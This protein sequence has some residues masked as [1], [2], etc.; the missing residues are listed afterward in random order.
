MIVA[1]MIGLGLL[2][3]LAW[4][5]VPKLWRHET[6]IW[7]GRAPSWWLWGEALFRGWVRSLVVATAAGTA[8]VILSAV[9]LA[10]DPDYDAPSDARES[11]AEIVAGAV[12]VGVWVLLTLTMFSV[13]LFNRPKFLVPPHLRGER[14]AIQLWLHKRSRRR[15]T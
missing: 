8:L 15:K 4:S 12:A 13:I 10:V 5:Q 3:I 1:A 6:K 14:G 9:V 2:S 7:D 11:Q